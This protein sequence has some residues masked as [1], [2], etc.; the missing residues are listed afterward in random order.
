[1]LDGLSFP[2]SLLYALRQLLFIDGAFKDS[3]LTGSKVRGKPNVRVDQMANGQH[4][5]SGADCYY[6]NQTQTGLPGTEFAYW[7]WQSSAVCAAL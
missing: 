7:S 6:H 5:Y 4:Q 1:M 3:W 2:L